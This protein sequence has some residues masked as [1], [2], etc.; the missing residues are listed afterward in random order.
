[1]VKVRT[2]IIINRPVEV[3]AAYAENPETATHWYKNIKASRLLTAPPLQK[4]SQ[5][6]FTAYFL[7]KKLEYIY[8]VIELI[9]GQK[10]VMRTSSGPFSMET[11]YLWQ[12]VGKNRT[13]MTLINAGKPSGFSKLFTPF[14]GLAMK[15]ENKKDLRRI[16]AILESE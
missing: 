2:E 10:L 8:D 13:K 16:K 3:V 15:R 4:G 5:I 7:G 6:S 14:M 12:D 11:T 9:P 1:M